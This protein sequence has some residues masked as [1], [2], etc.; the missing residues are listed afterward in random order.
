MFRIDRSVVRPASGDQAY[1]VL[2]VPEIQPKPAQQPAEKK[3]DEQTVDAM[4]VKQQEQSQQALQQQQQALMQQL[5]GLQQACADAKQEAELTVQQAQQQ[6]EQVLLQ[7]QQ[8]ARD[9][10]KQAEKKGYEQGLEQGL[11]LMRQQRAQ[12]QQWFDSIAHA[13]QQTR[14]NMVARLEQDVLKLSL[15]VASKILAMELAYNDDAYPSMVRYGL[16][17]LQ[18]RSHIQLRVSQQD[19]QQFYQGEPQ[20]LGNPLQKITIL[21]DDRL[22][23]GQVIAECDGEQL[24]LG[25]DTQIHMMTQTLLPMH[26]TGIVEGEGDDEA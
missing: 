14:H 16:S 6:A 3:L 24:D 17:K 23:A 5:E 22:E 18:D 2:R 8:E 9:V 7:A 4:A 11:E 25:A 12:A 1:V 21:P 13:L 10:L 15:E 19:Y 26:G 20:W